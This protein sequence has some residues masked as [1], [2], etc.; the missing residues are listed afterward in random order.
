MTD[1]ASLR[2]AYGDA[3]PVPD[4]L[5]ELS[6]D[7]TDPVWHELWSRICHQGTVYSAS[8]AALP[9]LLKW[10]QGVA[11]AQRTMVLTLAAAIIR[12]Q[13]VS[14]GLESRAAAVASTCGAFHDLA[15]ETMTQPELEEGDFIHLLQAVL[16]FRGEQ[17]WGAV[18]DQ[19]D[20]GEF[21]GVCAQCEADLNLVIGEY[22]FFTTVDEW[23]NRPNCKRTPIEA[24]AIDG[25]SGVP[26]WL[27]EQAT[28]CDQQQVADWI[29][30]IFG[31]TTCPSCNS[32]IEV[33]EAIEKAF[34]PASQQR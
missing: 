24:A 20:S 29:P 22:G 26:K 28:R 2:D 27:H 14:S 17:L 34:G 16:S 6:T 33:S 1:W 5:H 9:H 30:Y 3:S 18:F 8:F 11:P 13:D 7:E 15:V 25:L 31:T 32:S 4:L 23:V 21:S 12:S 19:L 10:S